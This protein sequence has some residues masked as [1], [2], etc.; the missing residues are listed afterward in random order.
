[1]CIIK[2]PIAVLTTH[3]LTPMIV[4]AYR[5]TYLDVRGQGETKRISPEVSPC[6]CLVLNVQLQKKL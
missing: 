6:L 5:I 1:M 2:N 3:V 4:F